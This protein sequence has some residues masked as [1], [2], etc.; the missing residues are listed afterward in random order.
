MS[1]ARIRLILFFTSLPILVSIILFL[2]HFQYGAFALLCMGASGVA[3]LELGSMFRH[4]GIEVSKPVTFFLG[5]LGP[6][7]AYGEG[8]GGWRSSFSLALYVLVL[9]ILFAIEIPKKVE[10]AFS[11]SL[12]RMAAYTFVSFYPGIFSSYAVRLTQFEEGGILVLVFLLSTFLND[13]FAWVFGML[14]GKNNRNI[15]LV[16]PNKSLVGFVFGFVASILV[17]GISTILFPRIFPFSLSRS[18]LFGSIIGISTLVG[19]LVESVIKRSAAVKDSGSLIPGRGGLLDSIDSPL[20]NAPVFFY[21]YQW[22]IGK[23]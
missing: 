12:P 23:F 9:S 17:I 4:R 15:L 5:F 10:S 18:L 7:V 19:D 11:Y 1:N 14:F 22:F 3:A 6:L 2:P 13:S 20:F 16:S 8:L 21:L